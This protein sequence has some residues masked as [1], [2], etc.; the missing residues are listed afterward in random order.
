M[1]NLKKF[2]IKTRT[3]L[4]AV[5]FS[6]C[7]PQG[8]AWAQASEQTGPELASL[9]ASAQTS[10]LPIAVSS[11]SDAYILGPGDEIAITVFGYEEYTATKIIAPD[12]TITMPIVGSLNIESTTTTT[13]ADLIANSLNQFLLNPVVTVDAVSLRPLS[14][15]VAGEVQRPG[16][17]QLPSLST[18][19]SGFDDNSIQPNLPTLSSALLKAGGVNS[20]ANIQ[21]IQVKR[22][23]PNGRETILTVNL[24]DDIWANNAEDALFL[25]DGDDIFVPQITDGSELDRRLIAR[26]TL[27]P[28]TVRVRVVGEVTRPGEAL[29]SPNSSLSSAIAVSGGP[30]EDANLSKVAF[31]RLN[32]TGEVERE[33]VNLSTLTD[34]YQVQDGDV[35]IVPK[36]NTFTTLDF[37]ARLLNPLGG[38]FSIFNFFTD[39]D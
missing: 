16:P 20:N 10:S 34:T 15:T 31:I 6:F 7:L 27:A 1:L 37:A 38:L 32:D 29:V 24:W 9:Q 4:G 36:G 22:F 23:L 39:N 30:T 25:Q 18:V 35:L 14:I 28:D 21:E 33:I 13:A 5:L 19:A 11:S 3:L 17:I 12:G 8:I 2:P 26:S